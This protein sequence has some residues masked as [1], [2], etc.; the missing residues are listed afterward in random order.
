MPQIMSILGLAIFVKLVCDEIGGAMV[1]INWSLYFRYI[2]NNI[3][4]NLKQIK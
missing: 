4:S 1:R 3:F 2:K